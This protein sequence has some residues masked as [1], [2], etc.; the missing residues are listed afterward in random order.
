MGDY[1]F[2]ILIIVIFLYEA[3]MLFTQ[4]NGGSK[5][6]LERYTQESLAKFSPIGGTLIVLFIIYE[7]IEVLHKADILHF[8]PMDEDGRFPSYISLPAIGIFVVLY[9]VLYYTILKKKPENDVPNG[10]SDHSNKQDEDE[11]F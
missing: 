4:K 8:I 7:V 2:N 1:L 10:P 5:R 6:N 3:F 11:E 9:L